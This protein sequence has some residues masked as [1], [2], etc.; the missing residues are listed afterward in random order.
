MVIY[1][2]FLPIGGKM[3]V[4]LSGNWDHSLDVPFVTEGKE[5]MKCTF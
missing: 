2:V 5:L 4:G 1:P 3:G